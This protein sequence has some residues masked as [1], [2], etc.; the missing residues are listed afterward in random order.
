MTSI[1]R[2]QVAGR[3]LPVGTISANGDPFM[4]AATMKLK[5]LSEERAIIDNQKSIWIVGFVRY[6]DFFGNHHVTGFAEVLDVWDGK[7]IRRGDET[8]NY[9][10][11]E[12]EGDIPS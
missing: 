12:R 4:E 9:A 2:T 3:P 10:V 5:F 1:D 6:A 11:E 8:Y 7:Y